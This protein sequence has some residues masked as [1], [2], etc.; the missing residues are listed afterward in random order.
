MLLCT[1]EAPSILPAAPGPRTSAGSQGESV[2]NTAATNLPGCGREPA[3]KPVRGCW[4]S[5]AAAREESGAS[6]PGKEPAGAP[7]TPA[8]PAAA[9]LDGGARPPLPPPA[10]PQPACIPRSPGAA[11]RETPQKGMH[12]GGTAFKEN[13]RDNQCLAPAI[14]EPCV[15]PR[16]G[17]RAG[18]CFGSWRGLG[19][20]GTVPGSVR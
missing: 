17:T 11:S 6:S 5:E 2:I 20:T 13:P 4:R 3:P 10:C 9:P 16:R 19:V 12:R 18:S 1:G 15:F 7:S 14:T 8:N